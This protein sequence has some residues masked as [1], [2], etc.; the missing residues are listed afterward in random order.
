MKSAGLYLGRI[1]KFLRSQIQ[2]LGSCIL[3]LHSWEHAEESMLTTIA[4]SQELL[5]QHRPSACKMGMRSRAGPWRFSI[6]HLFS[7]AFMRD[8]PLTFSVACSSWTSQHSSSWASTVLPEHK[9][10]IWNLAD[11]KHNAIEWASNSRDVQGPTKSDTL[12]FRR[13]FLSRQPIPK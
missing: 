10:S 2:R 8:H 13:A 12:V 9:L 3:L 4:Q 7:T 1:A 6:C 5:L 11:D